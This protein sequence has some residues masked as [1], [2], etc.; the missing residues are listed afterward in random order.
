[1]LRGEL[2]GPYIDENAQYARAAPIPGELVEGPLVDAER[3]ACAPGG[4]H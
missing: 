4:A 1:V 3:A 2:P